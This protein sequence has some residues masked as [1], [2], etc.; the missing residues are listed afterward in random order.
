MKVK[1]DGY[2]KEVVVD[3]AL[4][5]FM[6]VVRLGIYCSIIGFVERIILTSNTLAVG[7][8]A[9]GISIMIVGLLGITWI[10]IQPENWKEE[11][12]HIMIITTATVILM[13]A[14]VVLM[15]IQTHSEN[16]LS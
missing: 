2:N 14:F 3:K 7:C 13:T 11:V 6:H 8:L 12:Y 10:L 9:V 5:H 1:K 15:I 4:T 16:T